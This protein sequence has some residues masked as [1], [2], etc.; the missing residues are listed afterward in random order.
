MLALVKVKN[1]SHFGIAVIREGKIVNLIE[2]SIEP[3]SDLAMP[4]VYFLKLE[5]L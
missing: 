5:F 4:G 1:S 2:K 3:K